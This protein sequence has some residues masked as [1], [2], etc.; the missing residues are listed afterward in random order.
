MKE[1]R[2]KIGAFLMALVVLFS[3]MSFTVSQHFCGGDL[4]D[5]A[6]FSKAHSCSMEKSNSCEIEK[7]CC[8]NLIKQIEGNKFVNTT[9]EQLNTPQKIFLA[10]FVY[11]YINLFEGLKQ[12]VIP[13]KNYTP[14]LLVSNLQVTNQVFLI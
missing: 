11:S 4:M 9:V 2:N 6:V 14:P 13:F 1:I 5:S 3:T 12:N 8:E 10:S 7:D